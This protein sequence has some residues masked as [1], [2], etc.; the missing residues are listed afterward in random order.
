MLVEINLELSSHSSVC[1]EDSP[2][3]LLIAMYKYFVDDEASDAVIV[4]GNVDTRDE[5]AAASARDRLNSYDE[6]E[7]K[8]VAG[9]GSS[10]VEDEVDSTSSR[11]MNFSV[12]RDSLDNRLRD[13]Y[14]HTSD[15][16]SDD[17]GDDGGGGAPEYR[18]SV[19][20]NWSSSDE[21]TEKYREHRSSLFRRSETSSPDYFLSPSRG[22]LIGLLASA[23]IVLIVTWIVIFSPVDLKAAVN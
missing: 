22:E 18:Q 12:D 1:V 15:N 23:R 2:C 13:Y 8:H 4:R 16:S 7:V 20:T 21:E 5:G 6:E 17:A 3:P 19:T 11:D 10:S 9:G 14:E